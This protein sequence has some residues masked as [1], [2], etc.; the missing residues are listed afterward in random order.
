MDHHG[1]VSYTMITD[2]TRATVGRGRT[3]VLSSP[4]RYLTDDGTGDV[5]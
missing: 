5:L 2:A 4:T 1:A 3:T